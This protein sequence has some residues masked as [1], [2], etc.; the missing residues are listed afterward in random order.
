MNQGPKP[1]PPSSP[2][3]SAEQDAIDEAEL[4]RM[5]ADAFPEERSPDSTV[6]S[7]PV[8]QDVCQEPILAGRNVSNPMPTQDHKRHDSNTATSG[9]YFALAIFF[10]AGNLT[11]WTWRGARIETTQRETERTQ[12]TQEKTARIEAETIR[13]RS[14]IPEEI[15]RQCGANDRSRTMNEILYGAC[16]NVHEIIDAHRESIRQAEIARCASSLTLNRCMELFDLADSCVE[17]NCMGYGDD[18]H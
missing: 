10:L 11:G 16:D 8:E 17:T 15:V 3:G 6:N 9:W 18:Q 14:L 1:S 2:D 13:L 5:L 7:V 12:K 4:S